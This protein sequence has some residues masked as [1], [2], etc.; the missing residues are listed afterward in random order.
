MSDEQ[1]PQSPCSPPS[2]SLSPGPTPWREGPIVVGVCAMDKKAKSKPMQ[3]ILSRLQA[4]GEFK[5]VL[6]GSECILNEP[7]ESWPYCD[8]LISFFSGGFPLEKSKEYVNLRKPFCINDSL[9]QNILFDRLE[10]YR[11]LESNG[12]PTPR[13][14][15]YDHDNP[16]GSKLE[17]FDDYILVDG[18][19]LDKPFVEKPRDGEDHNIYIYYRTENGGGYRWLFRKIENRSSQYCGDT[20]SI[21]KSGSYIY[22]E[23]IP[24]NVDIKVYTIFPEYTLAESRKAP[25]V[26]GVVERDID[27]KEVRVTYRLNKEE[28]EMARK[29]CLGFKQNV[30]GFDLIRYD[31]RS[32]VIDVNGWSFV[33]GNQLYYNDCARLL[34]K[35]SLKQMNRYTAPRYENANGKKPRCVSR[36]RSNPSSIKK[37]ANSPHSENYFLKRKSGSARSFRHNLMTT[38]IADFD[39][40]H[41]LLGMAAV[42][43]HA[44]RTPKQKLK[45]KHAH[46][47]LLALFHDSHKEIKVKKKPQLQD[48]LGM[49]EAI[50]E[51]VN[52]SFKKKFRLVC[53]VLKCKYAGTKFQIK[54]H[55][56]DGAKVSQVK[57]ILKWGGAITEAGLRQSEQYGPIFRDEMLRGTPDERK[58]FLSGMQVWT[59]DEQRVKETAK[60]F[61]KSFLI[62]EKMPRESLHQGQA[63]QRLLDDISSASPFIEPVKD[64]IFE[65]MTQ[66][67]VNASLLGPTESMKPF[68]GTNTPWSEYSLKRIRN[69]LKRMQ[70]V[71]AGVR[72]L[73]DRINTQLESDPKA[74]MYAREPLRIMKKRWDILARDLY[75][76]E[77]DTWNTTKLPDVHDCLKYDCLHNKELTR[78]MERFYYDTKVICDFVI[79]AEY[80]ITN[81]EKLKIGTLIAGPLMSRIIANLDS[82]RSESAESRVFLYFTSE[83]Y[84]NAFKN[85]LLYSHTASNAVVAESVDSMTI[86]Y[87]THGVIRLFQ[88]PTR[89]PTD[90]LHLYVS[91]MFTPGAASNVFACADEWDALPVSVP[92]PLAGRLAYADFR[93]RI[94][95]SLN[96]LECAIPSSDVEA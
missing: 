41:I 62:N 75:D 17:E 44:D 30:C 24:A 8:V 26:D 74:M 93:D 33:K 80:G 84:L 78:G 1:I 94:S 64:R 34:R 56:F 6:F 85:I 23:F 19:R 42:F 53:E 50:L 61:V 14:F 46:V 54:P 81:D 90:P 11:T 71:L 43:R 58:G 73:Q 15:F 29:V 70:K 38:A 31:H 86:N 18:N 57:V 82:T 7:V 16:G 66:E 9:S 92:L 49:F 95:K 65:I 13:Y 47:R 4:Y 5:I 21:R 39:K 89:P 59:S 83:S 79:P 77:T 67:S 10:V 37:H 20:S 72:E 25:T 52:D 63:T 76:E 22:E 35:W 45:F 28:K 60:T 36:R 40:R 69:P 96:G 48:M 32:F 51:D 3:N 91:I 12:V 68:Y 87:F 27:G 55:K 88:D 2:S